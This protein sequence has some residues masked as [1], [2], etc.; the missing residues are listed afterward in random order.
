MSWRDKITTPWGIAVFMAAMVLLPVLIYQVGFNYD[1][2]RVPDSS[3]VHR[4]T[5]IFSQFTDT[6][7]CE[8]I[9][10]HRTIY[11]GKIPVDIFAPDTTTAGDILVLPGWNFS[12]KLWC[13][14]TTLCSKAHAIGYRLILPEMSKSVYASKYFPETRKDWLAYP[15]LSWVTDTLIPM[16]QK[17]YCIFTH[18]KNYVVGLSTGARGVVRVIEYMPSFFNAGAALSGDYDQTK[19]TYDGVT[20][21]FYGDYDSN[22]QR[23]ATVDNPTYDIKKMNTPLY[24]GHGRAD[25]TEPFSQSQNFY[26]DLKKAHPNL[27]VELHAVDNADHNFKYWNSEVDSVLSFFSRNK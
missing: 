11:A 18:K 1:L 25:H 21:G 2:K 17:K 5:S 4:D 12:R 9:T 14:S 20:I 13:D 23:W 10:G 26:N 8:K 27:I 7:S 19:I 22:K 6:V 3:N 16:L 15:K 24:L